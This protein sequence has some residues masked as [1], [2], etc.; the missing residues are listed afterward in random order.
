MSDMDRESPEEE[1]LDVDEVSGEE[2]ELIAGL[3]DYG[4]SE[5]ENVAGEEQVPEVDQAGLAKAAE[6]SAPAVG[7]P[8]VIDEKKTE[9]SKKASEKRAKKRTKDTAARNKKRAKGKNWTAAQLADVLKKKGAEGV[10]CALNDRQPKQGVTTLKG[11]NKWASLIT[12][13]P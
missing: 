3:E 11:A 13:L 6:G 5:Q 12:A 8:K 2:D 7:A 10:I 9:A 1:A 4:E